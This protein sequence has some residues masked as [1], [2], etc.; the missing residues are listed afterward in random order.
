MMADAGKVRVG[1]ELITIVA[2]GTFTQ[3]KQFEE[4]LIPIQGSNK[5]IHL[6]DI[7]RVYRGYV[8]PQS[9]ILRYDGQIG[10]GIGVS[11]KLGGCGLS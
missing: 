6:K 1:T 9:T 5:L 10:V 11:T 4:L 7:A 2:T 3:V 8:E